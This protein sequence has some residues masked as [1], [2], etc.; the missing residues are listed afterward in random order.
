MAVRAPTTR[1]PAAVSPAP[2]PPP[3]SRRDAVLLAGLML[4]HHFAL[5]AWTA[6]RRGFTLSQVL[7]RWDSALYSEIITRGYSGALRAFL[8]LYPG[9]VWLTSGGAALPPQWVG[10]LLST[11]LLL[12]FVFLASAPGA[13]PPLGARTRWGWFVFLFSP[14]S[15]ALHSH[16]TEGLFLLLSFAAL[17][18]AW[19]GRAL[20]A[21]LFAALTLLT[22]NQ[23][24]FVA[25]AC[26]L[27]L[28]EGAEP[29]RVRL[30]RAGWVAGG[31]LAALAGLLL[32]QWRTSGDPL[33]HLHAQASWNHVDSLAGMLRGLWFDNPWHQGRPR[34][35]WLALRNVFAQL[36]LGGCV[37]LWRRGDAV[38]GARPLAIYGLVSLLVML[39]QG[40]LGNAFRFGA[41]LF[42]VLFWLGD[43]LGAALAPRPLWVRV[44]AVLPLL[45][46]NHKVT[47]AFAIG[48]WAY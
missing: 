13:T 31:T 19:T 33:A 30:T 6:H 20:P 42:P 8:P 35:W 44:L 10:T 7:D 4:V 3:A 47:H 11:L 37:G 34:V 15:F 26:V 43:R 5:W 32:F 12:A 28:L 41:V 39:P 21:A 36:L 14:A 23:G 27:L 40:D 16:H 2:S 29:W 45:W 46:L 18:C 17:R 1:V 25:L 22:R 48:G 9:T 38:R 24:L